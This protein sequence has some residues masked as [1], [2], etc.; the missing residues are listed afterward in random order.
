MC[1]AGALALTIFLDAR[2]Q[3]AVFRVPR[4][5]RPWDD[6]L[7]IERERPLWITLFIG[8]ASFG[9]VDEVLRE[10]LAKVGLR[11]KPLGLAQDWCAD[12]NHLREVSESVAFRFE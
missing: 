10:P 8:H 1:D 12:V 11:L 5:E 7:I 3:L 2:L 4:D 6:A 9:V